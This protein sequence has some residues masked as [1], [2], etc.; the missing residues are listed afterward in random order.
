MSSD[1]GVSWGSAGGAWAAA[2]TGPGSPLV[3]P[4]LYSALA[5]P[6]TREAAV[7][8]DWG[9]RQKESSVCQK[10]EGVAILV[11]WTPDS[12]PTHAPTP[13]QQVE[14]AEQMWSHVLG[15]G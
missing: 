14:N 10:S 8:R 7:S 12:L 9:G 3:A 15:A 6:A 13:L 4:L 2:G 5:P 11:F 1:R